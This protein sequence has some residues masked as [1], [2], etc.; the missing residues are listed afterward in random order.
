VSV[1]CSNG[2]RSEA[3]DYCDQCG[4]PIAVVA[5]D[6]RLAVADASPGSAIEEVDT[7]PATP[8]QR[9]PACGGQ[10]AGNDRYCEDCGYDFVAA[11]ATSRWEAVVMADQRQFERYATA[12]LAFPADYVP[13]LF[14]VDG[15]EVRIGR[16]RG[17]AGEVAP[18]IDL[19]GTPADPG[20]SHLHAVLERRE[21]GSYAVRDLGS[22]NGTSL[23]DDPSPV[24]SET[25]VPLVAG[26]RIRVGAWTTITLRLA[27]EVVPGE[28]A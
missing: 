28:D 17:R 3:T 11:P 5:S 26:D 23:N 25:A 12:D 15:L 10:S 4:C 2:H 1:V 14:A 27:S 24:G 6:R 21:D 18:E 7:S 20:I 16:S 13:R 8:R 22:T 19:A 9:C